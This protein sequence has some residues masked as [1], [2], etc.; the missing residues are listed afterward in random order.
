MA[1]LETSERSKIAVCGSLFVSRCD[2]SG[3]AHS[4]VSARI[5]FFER[6]VAFA[7]Q[8]RPSAMPNVSTTSAVT[9]WKTIHLIV[10][11]ATSRQITLADQCGPRRPERIIVLVQAPRGPRVS[12]AR[13]AKEHLVARLASERLSFSCKACWVATVVAASKVRHLLPVA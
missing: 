3:L 10:V 13:R 5:R 6:A 7:S 4:G 12:I 1:D 8:I 11:P 9:S 2:T